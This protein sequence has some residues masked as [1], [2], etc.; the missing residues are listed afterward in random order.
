MAR[1]GTHDSAARLGCG[2]TTT[3]LAATGDAGAVDLQQLLRRQQY[4]VARRQLLELGI[5]RHH[6]RNQVRA[7]RWV[8]RTPLVVSTTTGPLS[9]GQQLWLGCCMPVP[10]PP[11]VA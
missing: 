7:G 4:V 10:A 2:R 5:D 9:R 8:L 11:S 1:A 6:V 3:H